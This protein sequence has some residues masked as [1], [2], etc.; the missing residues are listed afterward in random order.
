MIWYRSP[1]WWVGIGMLALAVAAMVESA[2]WSMGGRLFPWVIGT[3]VIVVAGL[4]TVLGIVRGLKIDP[5]L[6]KATGQ[7]RPVATDGDAK[8]AAKPA[9][10]LGIWPIL[11]WILAL[12]VLVAFI[13]VYISIPVFIIGFMVAQGERPWLAAI[14]AASIWGFVFF[15]LRGL[16]HVVFPQPLLAQWLG[17]G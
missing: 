16:I 8:P 15:V 12:L 4:H 1:T 10:Q 11:A 3:G 17:W 9:T 13:G 6:I 5:E 14:L 2:P 7:D